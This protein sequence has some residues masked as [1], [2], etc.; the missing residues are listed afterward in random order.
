MSED[1][2]PRLPEATLSEFFESKPLNEGFMITGVT[3]RPVPRGP[4][5]GPALGLAR[6]ERTKIPAIRLWCDSDQCDGFRNFDPIDS[7][8]DLAV[9]DNEKGFRDTF[10]L[11]V[12]RNCRQSTKKYAISYAYS[13]AK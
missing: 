5:S 10:V 12:C 2:Q 8:D 13:F 9:L 3:F 1:P 6:V 11:F 7:D 4:A